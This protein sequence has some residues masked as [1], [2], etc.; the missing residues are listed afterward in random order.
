MVR[1]LS[2]LVVVLAITGAILALTE[3][4]SRET[5]NDAGADGLTNITTVAELQARFNRDAGV[6]RLV[7]LLSPT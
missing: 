1:R 7:F 4:W 5:Q 3:P 2:S 6:P